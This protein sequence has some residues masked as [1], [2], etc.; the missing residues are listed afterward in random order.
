MKSVRQD[1]VTLAIAPN[2]RGF[3]YIA[4][5]DSCVPLDWGVKD[6]RRDKLRGSLRQVRELMAMLRPSIVVLED[7]DHS[8]SRRSARIRRMTRKI[9][10]L[11]EEQRVTVVRCTKR[12]VYAAFERLGAENKDD[13][14]GLVAKMVP[15]L[16]PRLPRR[17]RIWESEHYSMAI[18]EAAALAV[19][20][21]QKA[22]ARGSV[23]STNA[24]AI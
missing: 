24:G 21:S 15:A 3:G 14:A 1:R 18:F 20:I 8:T 16:A 5:E 11:V 7:V 13:I 12:E 9:A 10:A 2:S 22:K 23:V 17:R 6:V 4:F 19:L